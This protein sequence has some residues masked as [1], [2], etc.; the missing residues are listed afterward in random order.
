MGFCLSVNFNLLFLINQYDTLG[1][2][3]TF[4]QKKIPR[5]WCSFC[6]KSYLKNVNFVKNEI[7]K[8]WI[9]WKMSLWKCE[10]CQKWGFEDVNFVKNESLKMWIFGQIK[11]FCPSVYHLPSWMFLGTF[12]KRTVQIS[13]ILT[14]FY[15]TSSSM[16]QFA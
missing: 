11:D 16:P 7:F 6:Q 5:I 4:Y 1:Q 14:S 8:M 9:L 12:C 15:R 13:A 2:K 10:F 3:P